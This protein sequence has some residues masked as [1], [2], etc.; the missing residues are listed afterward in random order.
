VTLAINSCSQH[1]AFTIDARVDEE[2]IVVLGEAMLVDQVATSFLPVA[3]HFVAAFD[4][5]SERL[6]ATL[7]LS[8]NN[9]V[10]VFCDVKLQEVSC[11]KVR[12]AL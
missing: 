1:A 9:G 12:F 4:E 8:S 2:K 10:V 5:A 11:G 6:I 7:T 3:A